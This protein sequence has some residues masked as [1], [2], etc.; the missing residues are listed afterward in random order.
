MWCTY[1]WCLWSMVIT[2][3]YYVSVADAQDHTFL[4]HH[5]MLFKMCP[6]LCPCPNICYQIFFVGIWCLWKNQAILFLLQSVSVIHFTE[7]N[8]LSEATVNLKTIWQCLANV[9]SSKNDSHSLYWANDGMLSIIV[10]NTQLCSGQH[11][12]CCQQQCQP[13]VV[14]ASQS[15]STPSLHCGES[16][17]HLTDNL[18]LW[19]IPVSDKEA[20]RDAKRAE[21]RWPGAESYR[22]WHLQWHFVLIRMQHV[23]RKM[24]CVIFIINDLLHIA[25][26]LFH[27][28][29]RGKWR[30]RWLTCRHLP[31]WAG[32]NR[33][34]TLE[35]FILSV[36]WS[37]TGLSGYKHYGIKI[38]QHLFDKHGS[39]CYF[40]E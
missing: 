13:P 11:S 5:I 21:R 31:I 29:V 20:P 19:K 33:G 32:I 9:L 25:P 26:V 30:N 40:G 4:I 3:L 6:N 17:I 28:P 10:L 36:L 22:Q 8:L 15:F 37:V 35:L 34:V 7:H 39:D 2:R 27:N 18:E 16:I 14:C 1:S 23:W 38:W 24:G 12:K